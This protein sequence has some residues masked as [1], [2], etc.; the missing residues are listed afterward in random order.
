MNGTQKKTLT[1]LFHRP[2]KRNISWKKVARLIQAVGGHI[3]YGNGSRIRITLG[4]QSL[5]MHTPHP[6]NELKPYQVR[7][8]QALF[9]EQGVKP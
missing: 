2:T 7:A 8:L 6:S 1:D 9:D 4:D 3:E 5:N